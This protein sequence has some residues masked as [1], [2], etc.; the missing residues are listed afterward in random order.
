MSKCIAPQIGK[1]IHSYELKTLS[2]E[3]NEIFEIHLLECEHCFHDLN[4]MEK[5]FDIMATD[6]EFKH[7]L[8]EEASE[9]PTGE[10]LWR[11]IWKYLW[12]DTNLLLK[13]ALAYFVML[14]LAYP[15]YLGLKFIE[16]DN[17]RQVQ[18][19]NLI[20]QRSAAEPVKTGDDILLSFVF[21]EAEAGRSYRITI[22]SDDKNIIFQ[23]NDFT[24]FDEYQTG[25]LLLPAKKMKPGN[26]SL[27]IEDPR[28]EPPLNRQEYSFEIEK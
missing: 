28:G 10:T 18:T 7:I 4:S 15:S 21:V 25:K 9:E 5:A 17:I 22:K 27:I 2:D 20:P 11:K 8:R 1:L 23:D 12:P 16:E 13:P 19:L 3:D 26:Y 14:L 6:T 24:D